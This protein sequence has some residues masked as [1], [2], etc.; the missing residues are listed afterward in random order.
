[1]SCTIATQMRSYIIKYSPSTAAAAAAATLKVCFIV[2]R[3]APAIA[4]AATT[5]SI[6][7]ACVFRMELNSAQSHLFYYQRGL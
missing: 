7:L 1:M 6:Y 4:A 3:A 5:V 2:S